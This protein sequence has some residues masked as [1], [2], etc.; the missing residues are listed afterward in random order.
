[1][2]SYDARAFLDDFLEWLRKLPDREVEVRSEDA[3]FLSVCDPGSE[4]RH[5][6]Q[7]RLPVNALEGVLR[8]LISDGHASWGVE[9]GDW[10][11]A[12]RTLITAI[13]EAI[14]TVDGGDARALRL[15]ETEG[16]VIDRVLESE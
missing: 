7:V 14:A 3:I 9:L 8:S 11:V 2:N 1:M 10:T 16:F 6:V 13:D 4:R 12:R 15:T 5:S